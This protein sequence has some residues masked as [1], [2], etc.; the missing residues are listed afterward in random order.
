MQND[1]Q[2]VEDTKQLIKTK[3]DE[4]LQEIVKNISTTD[5]LGRLVIF[6]SEEEAIIYA[7]QM[8][9]NDPTIRFVTITKCFSI[10]V[11][12]KFWIIEPVKTKKSL[13]MQ[14]AELATSAD[15]FVVSNMETMLAIVELAKRRNANLNK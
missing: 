2:E 9:L 10:Y 12:F 13:E 1:Y 7:Q 6:Y 3:T 11:N 15:D 5:D 8:Q 14:K 4:E